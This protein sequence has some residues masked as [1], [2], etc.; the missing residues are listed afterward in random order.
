LYR[1]VDNVIFNDS[2]CFPEFASVRSNNKVKLSSGYVFAPV[3]ATNYLAIHIGKISKLDNITLELKDLLGKT[4]YSSI[5]NEPVSNS[6]INIQIP[7]NL[8]G[9][10]IGII[11]N[12]E[13]IVHKQKLIFLGQN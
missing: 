6:I 5:V 7:D 13:K 4:I 11:R 1:L 3:P 2:I 9:V 12:D 8:Q 10:F